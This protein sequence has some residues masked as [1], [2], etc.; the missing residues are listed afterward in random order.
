MPPDPKKNQLHCVAISLWL[1]NCSFQSELK[2]HLIPLYRAFNHIW[3]SRSC[4]RRD[5][6]LSFADLVV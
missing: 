6:Q 2:V 4:L 3:W 5:P 1:I